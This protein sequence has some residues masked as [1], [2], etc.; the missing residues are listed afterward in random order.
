MRPEDTQL[1]ASE[2]LPPKLAGSAAPAP[3]ALISSQEREI[4]ALLPADLRVV[5]EGTSTSRLLL[6]AVGILGGLALELSATGG[7]YNLEGQVLLIGGPW[8]FVAWLVHR[9]LVRRRREF[10]LVEGGIAVEVSPLVVGE[11]GVT[12]IPWAEIAD[13]TVSV[14]YEKAYL[15][16]VSARGYTLT[17]D[18]RPPRLSTRELIR[19]FV[20][21]AD[22]YPRAAEPKPRRNGVPLPDVTGE[23]PPILVGCLTIAALILVNSTV[24]AFLEPSFAQEMTGV[25]V[26]VAMGLAVYLWWTLDDSDVAGADRD[27]RRLIARLRRWLRRVLGIHAG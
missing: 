22:R 3:A 6:F 27:S 8:A 15:R 7:M 21:Q 25:A 2:P 19:R 1:R 18:D 20:E 13:Y 26:L 11:P 17:L 12:H 9:D 24:E 5:V 23:R 10:R 4:A 16:V 14:D